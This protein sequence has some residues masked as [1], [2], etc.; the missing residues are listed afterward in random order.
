MAE[1]KFYK[2]DAA[3]SPL[4]VFDVCAKPDHFIEVV[5]WNNG[6]GIDVHLSTYTDQHISLTWGELKAIKKLIKELN[7]QFVSASSES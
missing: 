1:T 4:S 2:L 6:E 3:F 7:K 5:M